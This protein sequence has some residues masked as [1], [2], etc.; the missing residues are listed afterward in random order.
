MRRNAVDDFVALAVALHEL[1]ADD[2]VRAFHFV[3][4]R[5]ADVV[6]ERRVLEPLALPVGETMDGTDLV[7][8]R[9]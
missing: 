3:H 2:R 1:R 8:E 7:E 9:Q 5:L 4:E 6:Q